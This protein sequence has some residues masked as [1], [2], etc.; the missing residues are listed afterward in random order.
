MESADVSVEAPDSPVL[1][2]SVS[3]GSEDALFFFL[4]K[5]GPDYRDLL[6]HIQIVFLSEDSFCIL[7]EYLG[8]TPESLRQCAVEWIAHPPSPPDL[9]IIS[10]FPEILT[11][12]R[13]KRF[14]MLWRGSRDAFKMR[15]FH[16]SV[17]T[18]QT[19]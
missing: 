11:E 6:R 16:D 7:E 14:E 10:D 18:T 15:D 19:L 4:L 13:E 12:P 9:R 17:K 1:S 5:L 2:E 8:I 3:L